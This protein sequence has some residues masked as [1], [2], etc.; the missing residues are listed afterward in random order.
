MI[1]CS[2]VLFLIFELRIA[3]VLSA[4]MRFIDVECVCGG[5][6]FFGGDR[7]F[8]ANFLYIRVFALEAVRFSFRGLLFAVR[9]SRFLRT[10]CL[11]CGGG[12]GRF[13]GGLRYGNRILGGLSRLK[14]VATSLRFKE[15]HLL[16]LAAAFVEPL[17]LIGNCLEIREFGRVRLCKSTQ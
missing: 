11:A 1:F 17:L 3:V 7:F 16:A 14:R 12:R 4:R 6:C 15:A 5:V 9:G 10:N 8:H 2:H 13:W